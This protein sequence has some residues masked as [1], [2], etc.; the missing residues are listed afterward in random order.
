LAAPG[1]YVQFRL[2]GRTRAGRGPDAGVFAWRMYGT[3][4]GHPL[5]NFFASRRQ[6]A[7]LCAMRRSRAARALSMLVTFARRKGLRHAKGSDPAAGSHEQA[8]AAAGQ[9]SG[10][11]AAIHALVKGLS[12]P[13]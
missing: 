2:A 5:R 1:A 8:R 7:S 10:R 13:P 3:S 9:A 11:A 4:A 12:S 6:T